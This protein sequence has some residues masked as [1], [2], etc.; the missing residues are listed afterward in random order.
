MDAW[1]STGSALVIGLVLA[2]FSPCQ[3][4]ECPGVLADPTV[5]SFGDEQDRI[6]ETVIPALHRDARYAL[7]Y[8]RDQIATF[9]GFYGD[10]GIQARIKA[11]PYSSFLSCF[12]HL[13]GAM[14]DLRQSERLQEEAQERSRR[15]E[16]ARKQEEARLALEQE[17]KL[18]AQVEAKAERDAANQRAAAA[19]QALRDQEM[20]QAQ[21]EGARLEEEARKKELSRQEAEVTPLNVLVR[22]YSYYIYIKH[23][24]EKRDG[25][26]IVYINDHEIDRARSDIKTISDKIKQSDPSISDDAAWRLGDSE[27]SKHVETQENCQYVLSILDK[28]AKSADPEAGMTKKDF[29]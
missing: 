5:R 23:C 21:E 15:E 17:R 26:V 10:K 9:G 28:A 13:R 25:Y 12:P 8:F 18:K 11:E 7:K 27:A 24:Y 19:R 29:E 4:R 3:A 14:A 6:A 16:I 22:A 20:A 2:M 1:G